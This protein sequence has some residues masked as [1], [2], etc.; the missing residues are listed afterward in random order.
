VILIM[1]RR[2]NYRLVRFI[3]G[4]S[5]D[6]RTIG[7]IDASAEQVSNKKQDFLNGCYKRVEFPGNLH[8]IEKSSSTFVIANMR[9]RT[10]EKI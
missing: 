1:K 7:K 3:N 5:D 6:F 9:L 2:A 10:K 8:R 4:L